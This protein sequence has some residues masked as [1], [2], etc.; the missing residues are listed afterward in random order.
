MSISAFSKF[1]SFPCFSYTTGLQVAEMIYPEFCFPHKKCDFVTSGEKC[2]EFAL[3][4]FPSIGLF[5]EKNKQGKEVEDM[6]F[7][8]VLK[9]QNAEFPEVS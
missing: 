3:C 8:G 2:F 5:R 1:I 4:T 6:K 9:K 7:L